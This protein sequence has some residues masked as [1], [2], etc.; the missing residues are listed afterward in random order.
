MML[1]KLLR[2]EWIKSKH[3][4]LLW[5]H[6]VIPLLGAVAIILYDTISTA[7]YGPANVGGYLQLLAIA[8]PLLIGVICA[9]TIEGEAEAGHFQVLLTS[10]QPK[11]LAFLGK[12]SYLLLLGF[13]AA[14]L[15]VFAYVAGIF[16]ILHKM[17]FSWSFYLISV[18]ILLGSFVFDYA[19]H[20]FLS[21]RFGKGPSIGVGITELLLAA[22]LNTGLGTGIWIFFPCAW[23]ARF[24][25]AWTN[26]A[27]R[28]ALRGIQYM[29]AAET[30]GQE[31]A[32]I[33]LC[34]VV[35]VVTL[36]FVFLWFSRWEGT[37][38]TD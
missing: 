20:L 17:P 6:L 26:Y 32:A 24:V 13:G 38:T 21:L 7:P 12:L 27:S 25:T 18:L 36:C 31:T 23:G 34:A 14:L 37:K 16:V 4:P 30:T 5:L 28:G 33:I 8:F 3:S 35:T 2:A 22:I 9:F 15:A 10:A 1:R 11:P 19:F 29:M